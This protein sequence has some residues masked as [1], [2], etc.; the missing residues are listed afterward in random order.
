LATDQNASAVPRTRLASHLPGT[1]GG[2]RVGREGE[3][4]GQDA[5]EAAVTVAVRAQHPLVG[6]GRQ[7]GGDRAHERLGPVQAGGSPRVT[8]AARTV[9]WL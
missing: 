3:V 2:A 5:G 7:V 4:A 1:V 6:V 8:S 9:P